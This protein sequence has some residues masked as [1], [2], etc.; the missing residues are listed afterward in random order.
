MQLEIFRFKV[1][2]KWDGDVFYTYS[3]GP[4]KGKRDLE[5]WSN[6]EMVS[7]Q[8]YY[9]HGEGIDVVDWDDLKKLDDLTAK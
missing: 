3:E 5:K 2:G 7:S 1:N 6:G 9:G 8:K 4:R